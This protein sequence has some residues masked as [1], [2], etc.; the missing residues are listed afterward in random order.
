MTCQ[1]KVLAKLDNPSSISGTH[2]VEL[3]QV[4]L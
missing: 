1:G 4:I 2:T 3:P